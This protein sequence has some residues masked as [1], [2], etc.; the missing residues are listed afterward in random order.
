MQKKILSRDE[1]DKV[2]GEQ[3]AKGSKIVFTNGCFDLMHVGHTRYLQAAKDLARIG[4]DDGRGP[5]PSDHP[6]GEADPEAG[7]AGRRHASD[8]YSA[9]RNSRHGRSTRRAG[10][11]RSER[12]ARG[13]DPA[14]ECG[15][16]AGSG[17]RG[18]TRDDARRRRRRGSGCRRTRTRA[19]LR[20]GPATG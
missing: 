16:R 12:R 6:L 5:A 3:R 2:V 8:R 9:A 7:L 10:C 17:A 11:R 20:R 14:G 1:L 13:A 4:G 18:S 15:R 19:G